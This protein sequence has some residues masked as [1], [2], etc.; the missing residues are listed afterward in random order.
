MKKNNTV[1]KWFFGVR[2]V[3]DEYAKREIGRIATKIVFIL[4][5]F[6]LL[7]MANFIIKLATL[8]K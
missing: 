1:L 6:E 4:F 5:I 2:G 7:Y 8:E 3:V